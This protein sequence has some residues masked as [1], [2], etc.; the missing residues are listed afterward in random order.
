MIKFNVLLFIAQIGES[1]GRL[2]IGP[3]DFVMPE[4]F[5]QHDLDELYSFEARLDDVYIS[6]YPRSGTT[7]T[8]E[9]IWLICNDLNYEAAKAK[10]I[11]ERFPYFE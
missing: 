11:R 7:W 1:T 6:T 3:F 9:M 2:K 4:S 5:V 10:D 8:Q